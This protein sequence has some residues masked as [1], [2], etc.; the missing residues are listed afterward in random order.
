MS[1]RLKVKLLWILNASC[2]YFQVTAT[3][4]KRGFQRAKK[5]IKVPFNAGWHTIFTN[6]NYW[7]KWPI[8][9]KHLR[10]FEMEQCV[11]QY[12][13]ECCLSDVKLSNWFSLFLVIIKMDW[14]IID[15]NKL[16]EYWTIRIFLRSTYPMDIIHFGL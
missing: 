11:I 15:L 7:T 3:F 5:W 10:I 1:F 4:G 14:R 16:M 8:V 13:W 2:I 12:H 9:I 6:F